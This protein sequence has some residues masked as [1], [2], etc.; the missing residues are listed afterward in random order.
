MAVKVARAGGS[1]CW[2]WR[3]SLPWFV[4]AAGSS[5]LFLPS[6]WDDGATWFIFS[7]GIENNK[8]MEYLMLVSGCLFLKFLRLV[9]KD[10]WLS[11]HGCPGATVVHTSGS[12]HRETARRTSTCSPA[13]SRF[14]A[15]C[16]PLNSSA[17]EPRRMHS[18]HPPALGESGSSLC[19]HGGFYQTWNFEPAGCQPALTDI[20]SGCTKCRAE[21]CG[22][23]SPRMINHQNWN[24]YCSSIFRQSKKHLCVRWNPHFARFKFRWCLQTSIDMA[25]RWLQKRIQVSIPRCSI[26][27]ILAD[28]CT[29]QNCTILPY[30][31]IYPYMQHIRSIKCVCLEIGYPWIHW[32]IIFP[33]RM[34]I[35]RYIS[36]IFRQA[37]NSI[38]LAISPSISKFDIPWISPNIRSSISLPSPQILLV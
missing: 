4:C 10:L 5:K 15:T 28:I 29:K 1:D 35:S 21:T 8:Q 12:R 34:A 32:P 9:E 7:S 23:K 30:I 37:L 20:H 31:Y 18:Q 13:W 25:G 38:R 24:N 27:G 26:S 14:Q 3:I 33:I 22:S 11:L 2:G 17:D 36:S 6:C 16:L 19:G